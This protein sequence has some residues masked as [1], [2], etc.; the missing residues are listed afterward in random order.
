ML[1]NPPA[2]IKLKCISATRIAKD[3]ALCRRKSVLCAPDAKKPRPYRTMHV[4]AM[5]SMKRHFFN[6]NIGFLINHVE[7]FSL[8]KYAFVDAIRR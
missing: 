4:A 1:P 2:Q 3:P 5:A 7:T 6:N 8:I